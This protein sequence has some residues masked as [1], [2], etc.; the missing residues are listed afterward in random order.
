MKSHKIYVL[1]YHVNGY[2]GCVFIELFIFLNPTKRSTKRF[3]E[4]KREYFYIM[5]TKCSTNMRRLSE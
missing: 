1:V 2:N 5:K 3:E 4:R